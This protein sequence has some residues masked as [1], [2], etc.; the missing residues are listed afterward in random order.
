MLNVGVGCTLGVAQQM[1]IGC[2]EVSSHM[3]WPEVSNTSFDQGTR[4][5]CVG[6]SGRV[7]VKMAIYF[8]SL[9]ERRAP[10]TVLSCA[11]VPLASRPAVLW[12]RNP[13]SWSQSIIQ[14]TLLFGL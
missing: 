9:V 8:S 7:G 13:N 11:D 12:G 14:P 10:T 6:L 4:C 3:M 5:A 2:H 1:C